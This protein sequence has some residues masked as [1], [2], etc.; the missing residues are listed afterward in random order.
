MEHG[1]GIDILKVMLEALPSQSH[2]L[3]ANAV[4]DIPDLVV[5]QKC[6][7]EL[8][9]GVQVLLRE[10]VGADGLDLLGRAAVHGGDGDTR[11]DVG[12]DA[13]LKALKCLLVTLEVGSLQKVSLLNDVLELCLVLGKERAPCGIDHVVNVCLHLGLLDSVQVVSHAHVE[14]EVGICTLAGKRGLDEV[15]REPCL[16]VLVIG[17]LERVLGGPLNVVA[18][19]AGIYAWL[20]YLKMVHDLHRL[21]LHEAAADH[22]GADY[23]LRKLCVRASSR[24]QWG[25]AL[26]SE[27]R[28]TVPSAR[29]EE[30]L[31]VDSEYSA[32]IAV[33]G[34]NPLNQLLKWNR[35]HSVSHV[36]LLLLLLS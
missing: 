19:V 13:L 31:L 24:S 18:L 17:F 32:M 29:S 9:K 28:Y 25:C 12:A 27:D 5:A 21:E 2:V 3:E 14:N 10:H 35:S 7:V 36:R 33:F 1:K 15:H 16:E 30:I 6:R 8:Y 20:C 23:V 34:E 26:L 22:V 4:Q 11:A